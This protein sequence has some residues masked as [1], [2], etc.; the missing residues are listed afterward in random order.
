MAAIDDIFDADWL[1]AAYRRAVRGTDELRRRYQVLTA[2]GP[3]PPNR[4]MA[5]FI[6]SWR[7]QRAAWEAYLDAASAC[8]LLDDD[9][10][11][12]LRDTDDVNFRGAMAECCACWLLA[13]RLQFEVA[14][15]PPGRKGKNL[16]MR[17]SVG[18]GMFDV[19][20]KAPA[21]EP[22]E[23][24]AW[25]GNDADLL[26]EALRKANAQFTDEVA[27]V[28]V[29]VPWLRTPLCSDRDQLVEAYIGQPAVT[30]G[31]PLT[32]DAEPSEPQPTFLPNGKLVKLHRRPNQ[33]FPLP[34]A[35]RVSAV[36]SIEERLIEKATYRSR[37][38]REQ[39][40]EAGKRGDE[41]MLR[42]ALWESF[43]AKY[44]EDNP[45]WIEH[46]VL[47]VH[48]PYA[49][50]PLGQDVFSMYPQLVP[51][52]GYMYWTDDA[53]ATGIGGEG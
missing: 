8:S 43:Q 25:V 9:L 36:V 13:G 26:V 42:T 31:V 1:R 22:P 32:G 20:V 30:W 10:Q 47:V 53:Q 12:R 37:F 21:R 44:E 41:D 52:E 50:R 2:S 29:L 14:P 49:Q 27:N 5:R 51:R 18:N 16:D 19:E 4:V 15:R 34:D 7:A 48:N 11:G 28:L 39:I 35:T 24:G 46:E 23:R 33:R 3:L 40:A 38:T 17:V 45:T 6:R